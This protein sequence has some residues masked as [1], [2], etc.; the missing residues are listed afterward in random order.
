MPS[1]SDWAALAVPFV[2]AVNGAYRR[3]GNQVKSDAWYE[4]CTC[5][6]PTE[7][8]PCGS[9]GEIGGAIQLPVNGYTAIS[10]VALLPEGTTSLTMHLT[11]H[12][13]AA[14]VQ[15][16]LFGI[17][18]LGP[19]GNRLADII[20]SPTDPGPYGWTEDVAIPPLSLDV[21]GTSSTLAVLPAGTAG[22][23]AVVSTPGLNRG[24]LFSNT[25]FDW[26]CAPATV[27]PEPPVAVQPP[28]DFPLPPAPPSGCTIDDLC[29]RLFNLEQ[30]FNLFFGSALPQ[31]N[32]YAR[33]AA[34][35]GLQGDGVVQVAPACLAYRLDITTDNPGLGE[36]PGTPPYLLNRG[37]VV[38]IVSEG[39]ERVQVRVTYNPQLIELPRFTLAL[40]FHFG[41]GVTA[42]LTELLRGP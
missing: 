12:C 11:V 22:V 29:A 28:P 24:D 8:T 37:F 21:S 6:D 26:I 39:A 7:S 33:G 34:H 40:G 13:A 4:L 9:T 19:G 41:A 1:L 14:G 23:Q 3:F 2:A 27:T 5:A 15:S 18:A 25:S 17:R 20:S 31:L 10:N 30:T 36:L 42:T 35:P 32:S 16:G 38:P